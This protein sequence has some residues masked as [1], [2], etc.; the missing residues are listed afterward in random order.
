MRP[1]RLDFEVRR[2]S[3]PGGGLG[4]G[5]RARLGPGAVVHLQ[6]RPR[7]RGSQRKFSRLGSFGCASAS[8]GRGVCTCGQGHPE[9]ERAN[10]FV[11]H[12]KFGDLPCAG[13]FFSDRRT[14]S[15]KRSNP[16]D[17][18]RI[19]GPSGDPIQIRWQLSVGDSPAVADG[20]RLSHRDWDTEVEIGLQVKH[21]SL[22]DRTMTVSP[23][24]NKAGHVQSDK[25]CLNQAIDSEFQKMMKSYLPVWNAAQ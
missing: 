19:A 3:L 2:S 17:I 7:R 18:G 9:Y 12:K 5:F 20:E 23:V 8:A 15:R 16:L 24:P 22:F 10:R 21:D 6:S 14:G 1:S 25:G 4:V 11:D 13:A